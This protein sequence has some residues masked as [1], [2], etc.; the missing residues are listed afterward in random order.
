M[1]YLCIALVLVASNFHHGK[2]LSLGGQ[3]ADD[4]I[5]KNFPNAEIPGTFNGNIDAHTSVRCFVPAM[6]ERSNGLESHCLIT[7]K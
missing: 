5:A 1:N 4:F 2:M 6:G 3:R 7:T